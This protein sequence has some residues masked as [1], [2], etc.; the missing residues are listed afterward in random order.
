MRTLDDIA[1]LFV[2]DEVEILSA[3]RSCFRREP[4]TKIFA[5]SGE[6]ALALLEESQCDVPVIVSD[7]QMPGINGIELI[8][9]V[10]SRFPDTIC[11][12]I[13]GAHDIN[14]LVNNVEAGTVFTTFTKPINVPVFKQ[15][16]KEA[17]DSY[18]QA[19]TGNR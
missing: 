2:D 1:V 10:K 11:M 4:Y 3:L 7:I 14:E 12:L 6:Q 5:D 15:T 17:I 9:K 18:C 16:I 13:S 19:K 8:Q